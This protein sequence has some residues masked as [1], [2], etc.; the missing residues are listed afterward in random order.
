MPSNYLEY[1]GSEIISNTL[2]REG[3]YAAIIG[4]GSMELLNR[5]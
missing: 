3:F 5:I 4:R 1:S 2:V